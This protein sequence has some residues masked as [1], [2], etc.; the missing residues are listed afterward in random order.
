MWPFVQN[1]LSFFNFGPNIKRWYHVLYK[2]SA[3]SQCGY[4]SDLFRIERGHLNLATAS[5][6]NLQFVVSLVSDHALLLGALLNALQSN[7]PEC[8]VPYALGS[9]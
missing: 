3:V 9:Q 1:T 6:L 7:L 8:C 2:K 5:C 4:L